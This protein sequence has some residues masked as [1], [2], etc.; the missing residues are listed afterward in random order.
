MNNHGKE[1]ISITTSS[2]TSHTTLA[3]TLQTRQSAH[4]LRKA[5]GNLQER[6]RQPEREESQRRWVGGPAAT[7]ST[8]RT[9]A[10]CSRR[11]DHFSIIAR[12]RV[13]S[14]QPLQHGCTCL[15]PLAPRDTRAHQ[16]GEGCILQVIMSRAISSVRLCGRPPS[17]SHNRAALI[18]RHSMHRQAKRIARTQQVYTARWA[19]EVHTCWRGAW[20]GR[21]EQA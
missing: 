6:G 7:P 9:S 11:R 3:S 20:A 21:S 5:R 19:A 17:N 10:C 14:W 1:A 8:V 4:V 13:T 15:M 16:A 12:A 18:G 2:T